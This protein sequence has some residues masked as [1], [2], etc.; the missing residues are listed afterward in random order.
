MLESTNLE[1]AIG[2]CCNLPNFIKVLSSY[3][4]DGFNTFQVYLATYA[5]DE[6]VG[7]VFQL[8]STNA[9]SDDKYN[10]FI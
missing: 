3:L 8:I 7:E 2:H 6:P 5:N 10:A 4:N 1:D 9:L